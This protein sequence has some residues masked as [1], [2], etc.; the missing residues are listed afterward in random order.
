MEALISLKDVRSKRDD[1]KL[2][3]EEGNDPAIVKREKKVLQKV[4]SENTFEAIVN[5]WLKKRKSEIQIKRML[6]SN[7]ELKMIYFLVLVNSL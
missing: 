4:Y 1:A 5:E 2:I 7:G 3:I 6:V